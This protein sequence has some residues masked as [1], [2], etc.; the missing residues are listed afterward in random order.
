M[1]E[2]IGERLWD[3]H[4]I[5]ARQSTF[6]LSEA[7]GLRSTAVPAPF[8]KLRKNECRKSPDDDDML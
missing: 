1:A 7:K 5:R 8:D 4:L 2:S 6:V 3:A